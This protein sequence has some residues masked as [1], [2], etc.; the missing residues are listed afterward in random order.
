[1]S[2]S[3]ATLTAYIAD[4]KDNTPE[5][6]Q[7][8]WERAQKAHRAVSSS[9][10]TKEGEPEENCFKVSLPEQQDG[11]PDLGSADNL[12]SSVWGNRVSREK[13]KR[14]GEGDLDPDVDDLSS[15]APTQSQAALEP[16]GDTVPQSKQS[17]PRRQKRTPA[18]ENQT[19]RHPRT[20]RR[21]GRQ[22]KQ[23]QLRPCR[24]SVFGL[25]S[26]AGFFQ[27]Q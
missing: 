22:S 24:T 13:K 19:L 15:A 18:D 12:L 14:K 11:G 20:S 9:V 17:T 26:D 21:E 5:E 3:G 6:V 8:A 25:R 16:G 23:A 27:V 4:A 7:D 2:Q 10:Q 1:M